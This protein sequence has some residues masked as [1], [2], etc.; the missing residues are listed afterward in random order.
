MPCTWPSTNPLPD[1]HRPEDVWVLEL[2]EGLRM[3]H[4]L[5]LRMSKQFAGELLE[6]RAL[7]GSRISMPSKE[8]C[9]RSAVAWM[10]SV[11]PSNEG[12]RCPS[13]TAK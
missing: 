13:L 6:E 4:P 5:R 2:V 12:G 9:R 1:Q 7:R 3:V 10:S 11:L 8:R